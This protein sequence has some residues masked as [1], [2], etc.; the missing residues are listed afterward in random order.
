MTNIL[1]LFLPNERLELVGKSAKAEH[2]D[3]NCGRDSV[4]Y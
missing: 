1:G 4:C 2:I 3:R